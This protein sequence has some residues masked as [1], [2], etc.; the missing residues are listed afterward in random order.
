MVLAAAGQRRLLLQVFRLYKPQAAA[1]SAV[2]GSPIDPSELPFA[3]FVNSYVPVHRQAPAAG[4]S[5]SGRLLSFS[6]FELLSPRSRRAMLQQ[7]TEHTPAG[8]QSTAASIGSHYGALEGP[9]GQDAVPDFDSSKDAQ[10][11]DECQEQQRNEIS[12]LRG[13]LKL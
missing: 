1:A 3:K 11:N 4:T 7:R 9:S 2:A 6:S 8:N 13:Q 5:P 12:E 10:I